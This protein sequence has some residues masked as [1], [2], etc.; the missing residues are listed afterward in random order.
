MK[1][2]KLRRRC[3]FCEGAP[4][5]SITKEHVLPD[6]LR[7]LFPRSE[8]DI[9]T[10]D[11]LNWV[12]LEAGGIA[13]ITSTHTGQGQASTRKIQFVCKNCNNGWLSKMEERRKPLLS[14]L[15]AG[16][17]VRLGI[18][19]QIA[20][21]TWAAKT[22]M[23]AEF[24]EITRSVVPQ[25]HRTDLMKTLLPPDGW[26]IWIAGNGG[27]EWMTGIRYFSAQPNPLLIGSG[28]NAIEN[29]K[30]YDIQSTTI[31]IGTLLIYTISSS[32]PVNLF[33]LSHPD[34][35][36]LKQI[37]PLTGDTLYWPPSRYLNDEAVQLIATNLERSAEVHRA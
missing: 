13:P 24:I 33:V 8:S 4:G 18:V 11:V 23:T 27:M 5:T 35:S 34:E 28:V 17:R 32:S 14:R 2:P 20:L 26:S 16:G 6:W 37:W 9:H 31:G 19:E 25:D 30:L 21:A 7:E 36:D 10:M 12:E 29:H 22:V 15:I 1:P 3:I